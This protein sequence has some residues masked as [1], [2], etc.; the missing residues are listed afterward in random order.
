MVRGVVR[1]FLA[2]WLL[3]VLPAA[4]LAAQQA[5]GALE[6]TL[7]ASGAPG[8]PAGGKIE[9]YSASKALVIGIDNY[10]A[11][12][13]RLSGAIAD[14]KAVAEALKRHGFQ[15]TLVTDPAAAALR[16]AFDD[17]FITAGAEPDTRLFVWFAG[18]GHT[19]KNS[20]GSDEGYIVPRDAPSPL[21]SDT[22]FRL[23]A[24]S[25]R[26]FG[27]YMREARA[28][29]VLAVFDSC[30]G[31][32]VFDVA[33]ALPPPAI[34]LATALPVRQFISSGDSGQ[35]VGDDGTF[36]QLFIDALQGAEPAA[37]INKDGYLTGTGLGQFLYNKMTNLTEQRQ[38]PRYGKLN[39][40]GFDR[41]DFVFRIGE[42]G[43][44]ASAKPSQAAPQP[45]APD[46]MAKMRE[47]LARLEAE[48]QGRQ[49]TAI[50][51]PPKAAPVR[52]AEETCEDG[53]LV[54]VAA[55]KRPCIKPGSGESFKDCPNCPEMVVAPA[56]S[57]SMGSPASEPERY[58]DEGPQH[59]V[60]IPK[61]FAVGR[62]AVTFAEWDACVADGG[63]GGYKPS[64]Q[65]WGRDDRPVI[66]VSWN[67]AQTYVTWLKKKTGKTYRLLTES[68][69]EYAARAGT[70]TPFWWGKS[71]TPEQANYNGT[72]IYAGGGEKGSYRE[73][74]VP[75]K[76]FDPNPWGLYQVHG[77]V[78]E[79]VED[80]WRANYDGALTDGSAKTAGDCT[81]RVLRGGSWN[82]SPRYLRAARRDGINAA[83]RYS[84][85]GF[86]VARTF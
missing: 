67:D 38:T 75:V 26:R 2:A 53:L 74:T 72:N 25:L 24:I 12:W 9:L 78:W 76:S 36:R 49:Q 7:N 47:R 43:A 62:F 32:T 77:N 51:A 35:E 19:I 41:G 13:P 6:V 68:E 58:D 84:N 20:A 73:K 59:K 50:I 23:K 16:Q 31:G 86:R 42:P 71:I 4:A 45:Q 69:R 56:G 65:G 85:L 28:K 83:F 27:E 14:A 21:V 70:T 39:A 80:C 64:D 40:L 1:V 15:V 30:F 81:S 11:G 17:F 46:E 57:F 22:E 18:H 3:A 79:W 63:C 37:D 10:S 44:S 33:R 52:P 55:G 5:G 8:A 61:P 34:T 60:T 29:H 66:N 82:N 48:L 54:S